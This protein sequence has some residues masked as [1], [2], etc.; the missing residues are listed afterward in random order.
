M[1]VDPTGEI[2][3]GPLVDKEGII[4]LDVDPMVAI[5]ERQKLDISGHYSRFDIL[6]KPI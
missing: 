2:V 4:Y 6:N 5:Q 3:A 1:A